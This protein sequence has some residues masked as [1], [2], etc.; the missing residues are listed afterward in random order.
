MFENAYKI[1]QHFVH[2]FYLIVWNL[3]FIEPVEDLID[4]DQQLQMALQMSLDEISMT[5][6]RDISKTNDDSDRNMSVNSFQKN[7]DKK[8]DIP[9]IL[10]K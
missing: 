1:V 4:D 5:K 8:T 9:I 10:P 2:E 6:S 7:T 3:N